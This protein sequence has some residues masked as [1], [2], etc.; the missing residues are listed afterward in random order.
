MPKLAPLRTPFLVWTVLALA[1][2]AGLYAHWRAPTGIALNTPPEWCQGRTHAFG[3]GYVAV[4][5]GAA[6]V[7]ALAWIAC[8]VARAIARDDAKRARLAEWSRKSLISIAIFAAAMLIA[9]LV[10]L[11]LPLQRDPGCVDRSPPP[12]R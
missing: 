8:A 3:L 1:V 6:A 10:Q 7:C 2:A 9:P 5:A 11:S 4:L 12:R